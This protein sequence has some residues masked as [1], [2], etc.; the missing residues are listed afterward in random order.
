LDQRIIVESHQHAKLYN[1]YSTSANKNDHTRSK[2]P[3][4]STS[5][6]E[7]ATPSPVTIQAH[8]WH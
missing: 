4:H 2:G 6:P 5:T 7:A 8:C 1:E 3:C